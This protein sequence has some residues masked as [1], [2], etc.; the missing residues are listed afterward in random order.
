LAEVPGPVSVN[1][2]WV[3]GSRTVAGAPGV[4]TAQAGATGRSVAI[5]MVTATA[6]IPTLRGI[7]SRH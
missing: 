1:V 7:D 5:S 6:A 4:K 2:S 3:A